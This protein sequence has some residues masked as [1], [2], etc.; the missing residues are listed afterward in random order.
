MRFAFHRQMAPRGAHPSDATFLKAHPSPNP[1]QN[2]LIS[3]WTTHFQTK[4]I[5]QKKH[6]QNSVHLNS[7]NKPS[8]PISSITSQDPSKIPSTSDERDPPFSAPENKPVQ[9]LDTKDFHIVL[10]KKSNKF[11]KNVISPKSYYKSV[12]INPLKESSKSVFTQYSKFIDEEEQQ[13]DMSSNTS[14]TANPVSPEKEMRTSDPN[15]PM[16][17]EEE[18]ALL[19]EFD[20]STQEPPSKLHKTWGGPPDTHQGTPTSTQPTVHQ[21]QPSSQSSHPSTAT[22]PTQHAA[23]VLPTGTNIGMFTATKATPQGAT[24]DIHRA[25]S[26]AQQNAITNKIPV[27]SI[28]KNI[29]TCRFRLLI[30][31]NSCNL[32]HLAKQ[33]VKLFRSADSSLHILPF[34]KSSDNNKVLDTEDNLPH[35]EEEIKTWVVKSQVV[36]DRLH[37]TMKFSSI[38]TIPALSKKIFP[39]MKANKSYVQMD[40]ITDE[41]ISC[42]G[43]FEGF[44]PDF[45][46]RDIFK[47]YI[48]AHIHKYNP[49]LKQ[50]ISVYPR[51][52]FAGAGLN[53]V[54]S[55]AV[56]IEV[57]SSMADYTLQALTHPFTDN[58][59]SVTFVPFT[60]TDETYSGVLRQVLIQQNTML[61]HTK[62]KILHGLKNIEE[63]FTM[64]DGTVM[65]IRQWL[66]SAKSEEAKDNDPLIQHVD[67]TTKQSVSV[68]FDTKN[69]DILHSLLR[70]IDQELVKYFP[71]EILGK[72]Y[73]KTQAHSRSTSNERTFTESEKLWA[74]HIKRKYAVNPQQCDQN[75]LVSPPNKNRKVL[76]HGPSETPTQIQ[77]NTFDPS[78]DSSAASLEQRLSRLETQVQENNKH[79]TKL[80]EQT[81][82]SSMQSTE[83]KLVV[84]TKAHYTELSNK[85]QILESNTVN[86]FKSLNSNI[87]SL[88]SNVNRLCATLLPPKSTTEDNVMSEGGK[89]K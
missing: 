50:E 40:K 87:E 58:Y 75:D 53:K 69:E 84:Q 43:L 56:V 32:P 54:E 31:G 22:Q 68:L 85:M 77:E 6:Q 80:I 45:R 78:P 81:I 38:K 12:S 89:S 35:D 74:E 26:I 41:T 3:Y 66:L 86:T 10:R 30:K 61:H 1:C 82:H 64:L 4:I 73:E 55:R 72:V 17:E 25:P 15:P 9:S 49:T 19:E 46:N 21:T 57:A 76:Y 52:V 47:K 48:E 7:S 29:I 59:E 24:N 14:P 79:Q 34:N 8:D 51:A 28:V 63:H 83:A 33:V 42:L 20:V 11:K 13:S 5:T 88:S 67:F 70:E 60:K 71:S 39:W 65:S 18:E 62:R 37:F 36:R 23:P 2:H 44:H 27:S 16:T